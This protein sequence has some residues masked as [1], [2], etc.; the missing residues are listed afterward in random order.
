M[1]IE[2]VCGKCGSIIHAVNILKPT[3]IF[4]FI[5]SILLPYSTTLGRVM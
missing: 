2:V 4:Y 3:V 5:L 1:P